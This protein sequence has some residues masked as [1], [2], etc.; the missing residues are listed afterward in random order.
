MVSRETH[1][2]AFP[3]ADAASAWRVESSA[4]DVF[5]VH[6]KDGTVNAPYKHVLRAGVGQLV[7]GAEPLDLGDGSQLELRAK[8]LPGYR[9]RPHTID[10]LIRPDAGQPVASQVDDWV[11]DFTTAV[12]RDIMP[13]PANR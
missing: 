1:R 3:L 6:V 4:V 10:A 5:F 11:A 2:G 8:G 13:V 12:V 9:L 7:F